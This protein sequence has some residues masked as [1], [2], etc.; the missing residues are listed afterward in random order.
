MIIKELNQ[1][2]ALELGDDL[3]ILP[4][5]SQSLWTNKIDWYLNFIIER[6]NN[7]H[8]YKYSSS[9]KEL[10]KKW[11]FQVNIPVQKISDNILINSEDRL[12]NSKTLLIPIQENF[13]SWLETC[14]ESWEKLKKPSLRLFFPDSEK[15]K[16][17]KEILNSVFSND[18]KNISV[19]CHLSN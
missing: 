15:L 13:E 10:E 17:R 4:Q 2:G 8:T 12:P 16:P 9:F 6:L 5:K 3:W 19:V 7:K 14:F 11:D 18:T 1:R